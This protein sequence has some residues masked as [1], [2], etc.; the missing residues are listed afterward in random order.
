[1]DRDSLERFSLC[2][3]WTFLHNQ[4]S[5][6]FEIAL[7]AGCWLGRSRRTDY[8]LVI[9][10]LNPWLELK[11]TACHACIILTGYITAYGGRASLPFD[12]EIRNAKSVRGD[13]FPARPDAGRANFVIRRKIV[14]SK[15]WDN[16]V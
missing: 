10:L 5:R 4:C 15:A 11:Q 8:E 12:L 9:D 1:M 13:A 3:H 7:I 2:F 14:R 16:T 6:R